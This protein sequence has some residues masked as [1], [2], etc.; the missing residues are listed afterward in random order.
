MSSPAVVEETIY[1]SL[2]RLDDGDFAAF[3]E[4]CEPTF[5]YTIGAYSGIDPVWWTPRSGKWA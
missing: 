1:A 5:R 4:L 3:L 2:L